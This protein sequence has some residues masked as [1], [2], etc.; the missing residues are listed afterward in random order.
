MGCPWLDVPGLVRNHNIEAVVETG[1]GFGGSLVHIMKI[2][3]QLLYFACDLNEDAVR[4]CKGINPGGIV[5]VKPSTQFLQELI[6]TDYK[7]RTLFWLDAHFDGAN[8]NIEFPL[9]DELKLLKQKIGI[10][11]DVILCDDLRVVADE[12]NPRYRPGELH[13]W[14]GSRPEMYIRKD[15]GYNEMV[16]VFKDTHNV[17]PFLQDEG[18]LAFIPA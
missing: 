10:G 6:D 18:V 8:P 5:S 1:C 9:L 7:L 13:G 16:D 17:V 4:A 12:N 3:P 14:D 2:Q 15:F 11:A